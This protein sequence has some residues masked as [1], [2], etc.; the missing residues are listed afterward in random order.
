MTT[1]LSTYSHQN[2]TDTLVTQMSTGPAFREVAATLLREQ[3]QELYPDLD[4]DPNVTMVGTPIW[5][6]EEGHVV[7]IDRHYKA[8]TDV[9]AVQAV[10]AVPA[11]YI[12]GEHFLTQLPIVEPAVHLPVRILD[13]ARLINTLAPVM[14]RGY[15]QAQ[16]EYWNASEADSG[17]RWHALAAT[18]RDFWNITQ[19]P[20]LSDDDCQMARELY[21]TPDFA[22]RGLNDSQ[23]VRAYVID[24]DKVDDAGKATHLEDHLISVLIGRRNGQEVILTHSLLGGFKKYTSQENLGE[25]LPHLLS[26]A[27]GRIKV[28][29]RLIEPDGDFFDYLACTFISLQITA[30]G[31][32]DFSGL[33]EPGASQQRLA[34]PPAPDV[35]PSESDMQQ[36]VNALPDWLTEASAS[37]QDAFSRHLKDLATLH[38][39]SRGKTYQEGISPLQQYTLDQLNAE[40][41]KDH[42]EASTRWLG[43]LDIVVRSPVFWGLFP[44]PGQID[45]SIFSVTELALQNLIALP[46]GVKTLRQRSREKLP[47]WLTVDY[48][49]SL[50][51]RVDIG[52][53]YP[54]LIKATLLDDPLETAR[55]QLLYTQHLRI[56]LPMLALQCKIRGE[57]GI[58][59][60]GYRYINALMQAVPA[61]RQVD[62]QMIVIRPLAF[63]PT[64][65]LDTTPDVVANMFVIGPQNMS[66]GPCLLYRPLL[67]NPLSQFPS[68]NNLIYAL[69]QST[70]LRESVLAWL[71][72]NA[73]DDYAQF[74]FP[75][76]LPSPW[77]AITFVVDPVKG[78]AM[79]GPIKLSQ[80]TIDGDL[81]TTL[82]NANANALVS[83]AD[84][85]SVSNAEARW[86]TFKHIGWALFNAVLPFLGR[87]VGTAVWIWQIMDQVQHVEDT[88]S[89]PEQESPWVALADLLLNIGMAITLHCVTHRSPGIASRNNAFAPV[90]PRPP[91]QLKP[92]IVSKLAT[93][94]SDNLGPHDRPLH[95]SGAVNR[96][97]VRLATVLD[98]FKVTKPGTLDE[99]NDE[100]GPHQHL[101]RS[102]AHWYAPVG[103]RWFQ[104]L[105]DENDTV[106]IVDPARPERT[107]PPLVHNSKGQWFVDTRLRLRG[108]G[109]KV[110]N[111][112]ALALAKK[113]ASEL[114][115]ELDEF[116]RRKAT[117]QEGLER[118]RR[119][120]DE[121][122]AQ[123]IETL[124]K[125]YIQ[126]LENQ[127]TDYE[128]ALQ[129]LKELNV[130]DPRAT[131]APNALNYIK[132][133]TKLTQEAIRDITSRFTPKWRTVQELLQSQ[134]E[135]PQTRD[136]EVFRETHTLTNELLA[137]IQYM[138][139]RF[140]ELK[141]L[142]KVGSLH[143]V[144]QRAKMPVYTSN[145][146]KAFRVT[147]SRN[148]CL[149][150][151]TLDTAQDAWAQIDQIINTA[152][153]AIQCLHDTLA[154][155]SERRLDERIDSLSSLIEQFQML[156]E[157]LQD[158]HVEFSEQALTNPLLELRRELTDFQR[159]ATRNLGELSMERTAV[160]S[161][162]TPPSSPLR[163][164]KRF[165]YTRFNGLL[166]GEPRLSD[167]GLDTGIVD[168][169]SPTTNQILATYHE[170]TEG[171]WVLRIKTPP[172]SAESIAVDVQTSID[173]GQALLDE[174][175]VFLARARAQALFSDRAP[176]G[177]EY[178]YHQHALKLEHASNTI[179]HALTQQNIT[180][181]SGHYA[182]ASK[183]NAALDTALK[184]LYQQ[185]NQLVQRRLKLHPPTVTGVQWL[186]RHKAI[187]IKKETVK[188]RMIPGNPKD[189]L[190]EYSITDRSNGTVL[191]YAHFH[192]SADWTSDNAYQS[193]RLVTPTEQRAG[194]TSFM[195]PNLTRAETVAF[196]RSEISVAQ[197]HMLFFQK[198]TPKSVS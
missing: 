113:R 130:L 144:D 158:F 9:L 182:S 115:N 13:I 198:S 173:Q 123:S 171:V 34:Q 26:T 116:E 148:L 105:V 142:G 194:N 74:V 127:R 79:S 146:L 82:Y 129:K 48:L 145:S 191:W 59:E 23:A 54:A 128:S 38:S 50:I 17:P 166:I 15:Q 12:E 150:A 137:Q 53:T 183:V 156:D 39:L 27:L 108:G 41:L 96:T 88:L 195:P 33:R 196:Y 20:G 131:Y 37:D 69:Q 193:A 165:I 190:D 122:P 32:I 57:G 83:L 42:P 86:A 178:L 187:T 36:Y 18:L 71:P 139:G 64:R 77:V 5:G 147:L 104:V 94:S 80:N 164:Q 52:N 167:V 141:R 97:P 153:I 159:L 101:Y 85:Q 120:Y 43:S 157:R 22:Q 102:G 72:D 110:I 45:T 63:V 169:R 181:S 100:A 3:L 186:E 75:G 134:A 40:M 188:R 91:A 103:E 154:E 10:L 76:D 95:I 126:A 179:E 162:P 90:R 8:L 30:I 46:M 51:S 109:P 138:D 49:E 168:I 16:T 4:L 132:A 136:I 170:K 55:R 161:R 192:Y 65:R 189:F 117:A 58:N 163:P 24:I 121:A 172:P 197:A 177:I 151:E 47:D 19:A 44:V 149:R 176:F 1:P 66:A 29:W 56:Q 62:G 125:A 93:I 143:L 106:L 35:T 25:D 92:E 111:R 184:D 31:G 99:I 84:R 2:L 175:P 14:L 81:F 78:W 28:Q 107:G 160:R 67:D 180:E 73:R 114:R 60:L 112:R 135:L 185:S 133:Q 11:L 98:S 174:L 89:H 118:A 87:T 7:P 124:R 119:E 61:D 140:M 155:I 6:I 152:D 21:R 68:P 70:S